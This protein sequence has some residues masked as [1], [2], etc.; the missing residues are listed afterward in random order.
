[1]AFTES[2]AQ[3]GNEKSY[4]TCLKGF[5]LCTLKDHVFMQ[6]ILIN[7]STSGSRCTAVCVGKSRMYNDT[8]TVLG[9]PGRES[10]LPQ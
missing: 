10:P 4:L 7:I 1:M 5:S 6:Y 2:P 9:S 8:H 3:V